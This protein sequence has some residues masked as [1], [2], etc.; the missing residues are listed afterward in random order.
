MTDIMYRADTT[1]TAQS[2]ARTVSAHP[3]TPT[4]PAMTAQPFRV[5]RAARRTA[6]W[7]SLSSPQPRSFMGTPG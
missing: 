3:R 5:A 1:A 4:V 2:A 7:Y 6:W